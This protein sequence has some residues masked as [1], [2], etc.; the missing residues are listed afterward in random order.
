V[1]LA[2]RALSL[3]LVARVGLLD[4]V[5]RQNL[6]FRLPSVDLHR[7]SSSNDLAL[8]LLHPG[9]ARKCPTGRYIPRER[10]LRISGSEKHVSVSVFRDI[11]GDDLTAYL[12]I[13]AHELRSLSVLHNLQRFGSRNRNKANDIRR[14]G[15]NR[16]FASPN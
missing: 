4:L 7:T 6:Y 12:H 9:A 14:S 8:E 13:F 16:D 11:D 3:A 2:G 10:L 1:I 15:S 5:H